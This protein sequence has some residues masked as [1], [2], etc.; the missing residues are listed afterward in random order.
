MVHT[1]SSNLPLQL[2][3]FVGHA[4]ELAEVKRLLSTTRLLTLTGAGGVGKTRLALQVV[5]DLLDAKQFSDGVWLVELAPLLDSARVPQTVGSAFG[6]QESRGR[7]FGETLSHYLRQKELLIVL[8]NCEHVIEAC[9]RL[10]ED[11]LRTCPDLWLLA[12]SRENLGIAG[13]ISFR[14][15]SLSLPDPKQ[16]LPL[17][18]LA[19]YEAICLFVERA[20]AA[21]SDFRLTSAN[22]AAVTDICHRLDGMPLAIELA[23]ARVKALP[24]EQIAARLDDSFKLLTRGRRT[25]PSRHQTLRAAM[26]W[27]HDLLPKEEQILFRRLSVFA[28]GWTL[29][30]AEAVC[31]GDGIEAVDVLDLLTRLV[32]KS[33][34]VVEERRGEARYRF[35]ETTRQYACG[36]MFAAGET[37]RVRE[38]HLSFFLGLAEQAEP[39]LKSHDQRV[40]C[41]RLQMD[42]NN[43]R[44]ALALAVSSDTERAVRLMWSLHWFWLTQ[45]N[46]VEGREWL[47]RLLE[48]PERLG[49]SA[50]R[51]RVLNAAGTLAWMQRD[52]DETRTLFDA[53]LE[54]ARRVGDKWGIAYALVG[55]GLAEAYRGDPQAAEAV[56][57]ILEEGLARFQELGDAWYTAFAVHVLAAGVLQQG[58]W[59]RAQALMEEGLAQ[60][61]EMGDRT[62]IGMELND[63]GEVAR[64][65]G[66]YARASTLHEEALE[67]RRAAVTTT[68][69]MPIGISLINLGYVSL[70]LGNWEKARAL[71]EEGLPIYLEHNNRNVASFALIGLAGVLGVVGK[72]EQAARLFG[73]AEALREA[74]GMGDMMDPPDRADYEYLLAK[75][76]GQLDPAVFARVWGEGKKMTQEQAVEYA[77]AEQVDTPRL[78]PPTAPRDPNALTPREVEVLR[79]VAAG[80]SDAKIAEKLVISPR[81][82]NTHLTAI[83]GKLGVNSRSAATRYA[84]DHKLV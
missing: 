4:R 67:M 50:E 62:L 6:L 20:A 7:P 1:L 82:V 39:K 71:F 57:P 17:E 27:S 74:I 64:A 5:A 24:V 32:D 33:L 65:R 22:A 78:I 63:L 84:L 47:G 72:P 45:G 34:V 41:D 54:I 29:E 3:S 60:F 61:R 38:R 53:S 36:K 56:R 18:A 55:I 79:L 21:Q 83:Y 81:T 37:E 9:A 52:L 28:G 76:C 46:L 12:T 73:A 23:A 26:D 8:D 42:Y 35:L 40:W 69:S 59:V 49:Q 43:L 11:L 44:V 80:L 68:R 48:P 58:D 14:V 15:P 13:E 2:T 31:A 70:R 30:A 10:A 51:A 16:Q 19:H 75:V 66:D 77:L 25:A